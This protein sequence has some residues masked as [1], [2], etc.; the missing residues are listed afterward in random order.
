MAGVCGDAV[1]WYLEHTQIRALPPLP[2][3]VMLV[4]L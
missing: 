2:A 1:K 3:E 4:S